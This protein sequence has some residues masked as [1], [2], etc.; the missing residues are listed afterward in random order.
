MIRTI[1]AKMGLMVVIGL[2]CLIQ[3]NEAHL[4]GPEEQPI[5]SKMPRILV[6]EYYYYRITEPGAMDPRAMSDDELSQYH[7]KHAGGYLFKYTD[8]ISEDTEIFLMYSLGDRIS[9]FSIH[10]FLESNSITA[11]AVFS[12]I[13]GE[14][15]EARDLVYREFKRIL[16]KGL[17][18]YTP[19]EKQA[20]LVYAMIKGC[21]S[22]HPLNKDEF[23][24]EIKE[25]F[26]ARVFE[27]YNLKGQVMAW[28]ELYPYDQFLYI[29]NGYSSGEGKSG[30]FEPDNT[31]L[32]NYV[33]AVT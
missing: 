16:G 32:W 28:N 19:A 31:F 29:V 24:A 26:A 13:N 4:L 18:S 11:Q 21:N 2:I 3:I 8:G 6:Y 17:E 25:E 7:F 23:K 20:P 27:V 1:S 30:G 5:T 10:E 9:V 14:A 33:L 22:S 15:K 12:D